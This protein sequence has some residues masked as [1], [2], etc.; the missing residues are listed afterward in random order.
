MSLLTLAGVLKLL[1]IPTPYQT[2]IIE[3]FIAQ[4]WGKGLVSWEMWVSEG[5]KG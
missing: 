3:S 2:L 5:K 1:D 4:A